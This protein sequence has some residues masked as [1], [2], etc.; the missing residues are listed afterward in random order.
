MST[1]IAAFIV[2]DSQ[3]VADDALGCARQ[4]GDETHRKTSARYKARRR[5]SAL[6]PGLR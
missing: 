6:I 3:N 2:E 5:K 4:F 1:D